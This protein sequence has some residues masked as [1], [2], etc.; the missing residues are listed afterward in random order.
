MTKA[1]IRF[2]PGG[3]VLVTRGMDWAYLTAGEAEIVTALMAQPAI[4]RRELDKAM[5]PGFSKR[6]LSPRGSRNHRLRMLNKK[7]ASMG[8]AVVSDAPRPGCRVASYR[9]HVED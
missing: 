5:W 1:R 3:L 6:P 7:L 2:L 9:L 8:V 4:S